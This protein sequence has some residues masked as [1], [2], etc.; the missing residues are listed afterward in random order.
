MRRVSKRLAST[1]VLDVVST[2]A[3]GIE[4][5]LILGKVKQLERAGEADLIVLDGPAAGHA[6]AFLQAAPALLDSV[7]VGPIRTQARDVVDLLHDASRCQ[8]MLVTLAEETPVNELIE[9]SYALED[10]VGVAL[11]PVVLNALYSER[12][13]GRLAAGPLRDAAAFRRS[14]CDAQ[15]EQQARLAAELPLAQL[16]LPFVFTASL[17]SDDVDDLATTML[18]G[19]HELAA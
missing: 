11:A 3:P 9:T 2:A 19:L 13:F 16:A 1:G 6:I 15:H 4:D 10:R 7:R 8:V 12:T 18:A 14:R 17:N 5:I